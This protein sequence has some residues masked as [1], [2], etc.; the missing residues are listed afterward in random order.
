MHYLISKH[1][2]SKRADVFYGNDFPCLH[3]NAARPYADSKVAPRGV[4]NWRE[5]ERSQIRGFK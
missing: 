3:V 5:G 2:Q 1:V 4:L